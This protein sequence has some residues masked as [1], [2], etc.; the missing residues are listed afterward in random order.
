MIDESTDVST[1]KAMCLV[2]R[3][4]DDSKQEV[5]SNI[6]DL[7][8]IFQND[9][10]TA[11][12]AAIY[13][14]LLK[15]FTSVGVPISNIIGFGSDGCNAMMGK[16]N[17]VMSRFV[18]QN[19]GIYIAKCIC[20]S[21]HLCA[22]EAAK[23]LPRRCEDLA[24]ETFA[25]FSHSAKRKAI[26]LSF[27]EFVN[28]KPHKLL[29]PSQ[30]R[31][32]S[33]HAV[34]KRILEQW[35]AL[36]LF[37]IDQVVTERVASADRILENLS[38]P[39]VKL[40]FLFLN[41]VLPKFNALNAYFQTEKCVITNVHTKMCETYKE[42]LC[43]YLKNT[44]VLKNLANVNP[45]TESEQLVTDQIYL[46][47]DVLTELKALHKCNSQ[48]RGIETNFRERCR[49]FLQVAC[50]QMSKRYDFNDQIMSKLSLLNP[51]KALTL[52]TREEFPSL[53][54]VFELLPLCCEGIDKQKIDDEWRN[55]PF[56]T[57]PENVLALSVDKFWSFA[58]NVRSDDDIGLYTHLSKFFLNV[59]SLP[60]SNADCE[61][62]F[63]SINLIKTKLRNSL[64]IESV[65]YLLLAKQCVKQ[66][67]GCHTFVPT[68][69]MI[70]CNNNNIYKKTYTQCELS[71]TI[72]M[73]LL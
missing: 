49:K 59:L 25:Y 68:K 12:A 73:E 13:E 10:E 71:D 55:L 4:F 45:L 63:S 20:H 33:L 57:F 64:N 5:V 65:K 6:F 18:S 23:E 48:A 72:I 27:Q 51:S 19:P 7:V 28:V 58:M 11:T 69:K 46:G 47:A 21:L 1:S 8:D 31:W 54:P 15:C 14:T 61:R 9:V 70:A 3:Y 32:L 44:Y 37:F 39:Q 50:V 30:T 34:V 38:D 60:H 66:S 40:F 41:W 53:V 52:N 17:S 43:T 67:G 26:F 22:S 56:Y 2:V 16:H 42:L 29:A 36:R 62:I 24:R 35:H